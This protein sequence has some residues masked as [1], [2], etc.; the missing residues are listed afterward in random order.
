MCVMHL[1]GTTGLTRVGSIPPWI[2][3]VELE[4]DPT[5]YNSLDTI[6]RMGGA[7]T[8]TCQLGDDAVARCPGVQ[9]NLKLLGSTEYGVL[10]S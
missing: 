3:A 10:V 5:P 4:G 1:P 7:I 9:T 6:S 2:S 8:V